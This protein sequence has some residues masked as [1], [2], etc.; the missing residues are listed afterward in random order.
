M[1]VRRAVRLF[2]CAIFLLLAFRFIA[3]IGAAAEDANFLIGK[4]AMGNLDERCAR[5]QIIPKEISR[6]WSKSLRQGK[7]DCCGLRC[8]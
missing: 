7:V 8:A 3:P 1:G 5:P 4:A 2:C 6:Q